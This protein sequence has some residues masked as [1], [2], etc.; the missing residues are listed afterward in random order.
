MHTK[1]RTV[2]CL[3]TGPPNNEHRVLKESSPATDPT[4]CSEPEIDARVSRLALGRSASFWPS[5]T[6]FGVW[7]AKRP[8][9]KQ[10]GNTTK[11][12]HSHSLSPRHNCARAFGQHDP[13]HTAP[14]DRRP[15]NSLCPL[16]RRHGTG[17]QHQHC[18]R[19]ACRAVESELA[20]V[21]AVTNGGNALRSGLWETGKR[22]VGEERRKLFRARGPRALYPGSF[23]RA[24]SGDSPGPIFPPVPA[25][26]AATCTEAMICLPP[27]DLTYDRNRLV[28]QRTETKKKSHKHTRT[29]CACPG[30][31]IAGPIRC[32]TVQAD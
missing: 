6:S 14:F 29:E 24:G 25:A 13:E 16:P 15:R 3:D 27:Y 30:C 9:S 26:A 11:K 12:T 28:R 5:T 21:E 7:R 4:G 8:A 20:L 31:I 32:A 23:L 2:C 22:K 10:A 1:T 19:A 18:P 17:T